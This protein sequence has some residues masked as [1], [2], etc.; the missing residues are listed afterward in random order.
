MSSP[1]NKIRPELTIGPLL[2]HWPMETKRD[3]YFRIADEPAVDTVYLGEVICSKRLPLFEP[4]LDEVCERLRKAGKTVVFSTLAEVIIKRDRQQVEGFCLRDDI[5]IEANDASALLY[6]VGRHFRTGPFLNIYNE[7]SLAF[8]AARGATHVTLPPELPAESIKVLA[9]KARDLG[10]TLEV[11]VYGRMPLALSARCYHARA[12]QTTKDNCQF[13]C[14]EDPDGMALKTQEGKPFL[15]ING[16]Q[17]L[18]YNCLNLVHELKAMQDMGIHA[19]RL[20]PHSHD[21]SE[22]SRLFRAVLDNEMPAA[23]A[24]TRLENTGHPFP[25]ANGFYY[26]KEGYRWIN[27]FPASH[28]ASQDNY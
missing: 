8:L 2:F 17:T 6:L 26:K 1:V 3:F 19:F 18:S 12:H 4:H 27:P 15:A 20:S 25:F 9:R 24:A 22:I 11:M 7:D 13:V 16:I 23:E 21:M 28:G 5:Y 14:G 10:I